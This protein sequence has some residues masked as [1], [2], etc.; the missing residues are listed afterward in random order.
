MSGTWAGPRTG[1][2]AAGAGAQGSGS[3]WAPG[4]TPL[5]LWLRACGLGGGGFTGYTYASRPSSERI[6]AFRGPPSTACWKRMVWG[7]GSAASWG[8]GAQ[9]PCVD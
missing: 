5:F 4:P 9:N 3:A 2:G 1:G 8:Q 6:S 7:G